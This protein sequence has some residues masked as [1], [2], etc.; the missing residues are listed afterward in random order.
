MIL[1]SLLVGWMEISATQPWASCSA[2]ELA[3]DTDVV[4]KEIA[5]QVKEIA[6]ILRKAGIFHDWG[7][8]Q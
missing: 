2:L 5:R 3:E 7:L 8:M 1:H 6:R 4:G